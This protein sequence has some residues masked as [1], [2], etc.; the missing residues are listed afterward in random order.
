MNTVTDKEYVL[1][2]PIREFSAPSVCSRIKAS[3][4]KFQYHLG[5]LERVQMNAIDLQIKLLTIGDSSVGKTCL[6]HQ[7]TNKSFPGSSIPTVGI[8]FKIMNITIDGKRIKMQCW[9]TAGQERYRNITANYYRNAQGIVLVYDIT[10][11]KSFE[12]I[13]TWIAQI[14]VHAL[15]S[16]NKI[17]IGNKSDCEKQRVVSKE[18]G[19][20]LAK[21]YNI[22]FFETSAKQGINVDEAF[23]C[24][25]KEVKD[26]LMSVTRDVTP[27]KNTSL[28]SKIEGRSNC[29]WVVRL[30]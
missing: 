24:I 29:C 2:G 23:Y 6:L 21:R 30:S 7:Y 14:H 22:Q 8:D 19:E 4:T 17:L 28:G 10:N 11:R 18:E 12:A 3:N 25:A 1:Q 27:A 9:D 5:Q 15:E 13:D 26:R 16:V 20:N